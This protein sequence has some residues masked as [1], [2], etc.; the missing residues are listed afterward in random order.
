[1]M[2][3]LS[4]HSSALQ[5]LFSGAMVMIW[6]AYLQVFLMNF[7][8]Q[9]RPDILINM[10]AGIG[11]KA[12]CFVSNLSL[13]P[14]YLLEVIVEIETEGE[15]HRA[16]ITDR[17]EMTGEQLN[18]P[19]EATNQG[20]LK[21][22]DYIDI[23]NFE[24][25]VQRASSFDDASGSTTNIRAIELTVVAASAAKGSLIGAV[26]RY[27]VTRDDEERVHLKPV[28]IAATQITTRAGRRRL[29]RE[30][31]TNLAD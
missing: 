20:P 19:A 4:A 18:N 3:W 1:M 26:R 9:H 17:T 12:R 5:V 2:E 7:Q 27:V 10:G 14:I 24:T 16:A 8:R 29:R 13:E 31:E 25:L 23:G 22:G 21:S 28:T 15:K 6:I 11:L 30:L